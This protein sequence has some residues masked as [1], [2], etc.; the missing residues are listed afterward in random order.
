MLGLLFFAVDKLARSRLRSTLLGARSVV[1]L[2]PKEWPQAIEAVDA[3]DSVDLILP[4]KQREDS[5]V[6][7]TRPR[8]SELLHSHAEGC[9][10]TTT[11]AL[12][13]LDAAVVPDELARTPR[14]HAVAALQPREGVA[15]LRRAH[16]FG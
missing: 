13:L 8:R 10:V 12:V 6:A 14:R 2:W 9:R 7:I 4:A 15:L 16:H 11:V 5:S 3:L 1:M